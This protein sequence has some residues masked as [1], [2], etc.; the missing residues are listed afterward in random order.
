MDKVTQDQ[1]VLNHLKAAKPSQA[2][3]A[4]LMTIP[5]KCEYRAFTQSWLQ[6]C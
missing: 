5:T 3:A 4:G 1:T 6:H 2:E